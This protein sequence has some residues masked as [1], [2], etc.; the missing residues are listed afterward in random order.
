MSALAEFIRRALAPRLVVGLSRLRAGARL[1]VRLRR[2][3]G[4]PLRMELYFAYDDPYAAIAMPTLLRLA[5]AYGAQLQLYPLIERGIDDD[6]ALQQ[7][8]VHAVEDS[9]R[10]A[11]RQHRTLAVTQPLAAADCAFLAQWTQA[12][13]THSRQADFAAAALERLWFAGATPQRTEFFALHQGILGTEPGTELPLAALAA[14]RA[15]LLRRGHWES[16]ALWVEGEWFFAHER[17]P[18]IDAHLRMLGA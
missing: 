1:R 9:R 17:L 6:P 12:A 15:R 18:Q 7:R 5:R 3:L 8:R 10:L 16:P 11:L 2:W 13:R 14:N 4:L